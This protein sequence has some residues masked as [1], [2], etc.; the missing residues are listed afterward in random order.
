MSIG[1]LA[2][3]TVGIR[4]GSVLDF[5]VADEFRGRGVGSK[6]LD[7]ALKEIR[8]RGYS[9]ASIMVSSSNRKA[10][11]MHEKRG[12]LPDRVRLVKRLG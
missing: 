12:F 1:E 7:F 8:K 2:N 10:L 6:L 3:P 9:H 5:W 4:L 11:Q